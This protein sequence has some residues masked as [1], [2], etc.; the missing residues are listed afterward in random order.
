M[1]NKVPVQIQVLKD[2]YTSDSQ[3]FFSSYV[4]NKYNLTFEGLKTKTKDLETLMEKL[5]EYDKTLNKYFFPI[6]IFYDF[7]ILESDKFFITFDS[8]DN[9]KK[10]NIN[11]YFQNYKEGNEIFNIIKEYDDV[12]DELFVSITSYFQDAGKNIKATES[13]K[14]LEDFSYNLLEYY[15]YLDV[16]ELFSQFT[17]SDSNILLL[18]GK[19]GVGKS[20]LGDAFMK[21]SLD[22]CAK[23]NQ[24]PQSKDVIENVLKNDSIQTKM[25]YITGSSE[26]V[27]VAYIKNEEILARDEFWNELKDN[28]FNL[29]FLDDLDYGLLPRT[30]QIS[31]GVEMD[32][33]KFISNLL[34]F[35]DGIFDQGNKTK[36]IITTNREV[37]DIDTAVLR[38]GR[39]FDILELRELSYEEAL[40]IWNRLELPL[41]KFES[42]FK[43]KEKVLQADLGSLIVMTQKSITQNIELKPY[44]K[45]D[46]IS[47]YTKSK[48]PKKIGL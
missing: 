31:S 30:Q 22:N 15:P 34:S 4:S 6:S 32:K 48:N 12:D 38:K 35:T 16:N 21:Y 47:L 20:K 41:D 43:G 11:L 17:M 36:F 14:V 27:Q 18:C 2:S 23:I 37:G 28:E 19:P 44:I 42:E 24:S 1:Q 13:I 10:I 3:V 9:K 29:V 45:E 8:Y 46:G 40:T 39:T 5:L 25:D 26:G 7:Y 33:N